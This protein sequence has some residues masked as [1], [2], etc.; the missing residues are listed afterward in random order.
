[1][2][3]K[4]AEELAMAAFNTGIQQCETTEE[5]SKY[6]QMLCIIA[7]KT[8]H[9]IEGRRFKKDFLGAAIKD[10]EMITPVMRH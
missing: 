7:A 1:M 5:A 9:G 6:C 3:K 8:I 4:T 2:S 10:S